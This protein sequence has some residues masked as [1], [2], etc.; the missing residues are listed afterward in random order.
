MTRPWST[1][2]PCTAS[3]QPCTASTRGSRRRSSFAT[4]GRASRSDGCLTTSSSVGDTGDLRPSGR[5]E[6]PPLNEE[7]RAT[8]ERAPAGH[9]EGRC[10][11]RDAGGNPFEILPTDADPNAAHIAASWNGGWLPSYDVRFN[12]RRAA[13]HGAAGRE[14]SAERRELHRSSTLSAGERDEPLSPGSR[15]ERRLRHT[16][17]GGGDG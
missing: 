11:R 4:V 15:V 16:A 9:G 17:T 3:T 14:F 10:R 2:Q 6:R 13:E 12:A 1:R 7:V 8:C 5:R